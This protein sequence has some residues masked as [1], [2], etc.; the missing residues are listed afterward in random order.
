M[1]LRALHT[2]S[3]KPGE[4]IAPGDVFE[5]EADVAAGLIRAK[6]AVEIPGEQG[7]EDKGGKGKGGKGKEGGDNA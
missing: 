7:P 4:S 2:V 1:K 3:V 5:V 6:A